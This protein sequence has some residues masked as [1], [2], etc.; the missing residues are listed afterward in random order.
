MIDSDVFAAKRILDNGYSC[1]LCYKGMAFTSKKEGV[2]P[3]IDFINS[4]CDFSTFSA[5]VNLISIS[6]AL[7]FVKLNIKEISTYVLTKNAKAI[8]DEFKVDYKYNELI[9]DNNI[10]DINLK[11]CD[12]LI[13]GINDFNLK[14]E[15]ILEIEAV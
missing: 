14:V 13:D 4:K 10:T 6:N 5:A 7:L 2:L 3:L 12:K 1:V 11:K 8:F 9:D 15:K